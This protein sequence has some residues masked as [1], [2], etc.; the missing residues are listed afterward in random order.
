MRR[1]GAI[2][3]NDKMALSRRVSG[4]IL[5]TSEFYVVMPERPGY[6][7]VN[8]CARFVMKE[9]LRGL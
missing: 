3:F 7:G 8:H 5:I 9:K 6:E 4:A 1:V 2:D